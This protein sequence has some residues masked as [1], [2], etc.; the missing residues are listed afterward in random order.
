[1]SS[2]TRGNH[3]ETSMHFC[4]SSVNK[5]DVHLKLLNKHVYQLK[6][7][8]RIITLRCTQRQIPECVKSCNYL[9]V[10]NNAKKVFHHHFVLGLNSHGVPVLKL[11]KTHNFFFLFLKGINLS[12]HIYTIFDYISYITIYLFNMSVYF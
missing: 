1:M 2:S 8:G 3:T 12:L 6:L 10:K 9:K 4:L 7:Q 5:Y 11:V